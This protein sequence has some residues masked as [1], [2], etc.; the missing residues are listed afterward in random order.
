MGEELKSRRG[1]LPVPIRPRP[2]H[3]A[4]VLYQKPMMTVQDAVTA[5]NFNKITRT[6]E[7]KGAAISET[8][9][10][11]ELLKGLRGMFSAGRTYD[12]QIHVSVTMA[13]VGGGVFNTAIA[14]DPAAVTY[15]E[16][17]ALA[18]LFDEVVLLQAQL[19]ITSAFGPTSTAIIFQVAVAPDLDRSSGST[20]TFTAITRLAESEYF[21]CYNMASKPGVFT[22][23]HRLRRRPFAITSTP[24]GAAGTPSGCLGQ[25]SFASNIVGTATTNYL[26]AVLKNTVRLRNRA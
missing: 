16:W 8:Y 7:S 24:G 22:K 12:F 11:P 3:P 4:L 1:K 14:W 5:L 23:V 19:D 2:K 9:Y 18:A 13:T 17:T 26:F 20:P 6:S 25:W 15:S 10:P 21:H